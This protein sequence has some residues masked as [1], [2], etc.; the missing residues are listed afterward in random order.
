MKIDNKLMYVLLV[1]VVFLLFIIVFIG[2]DLVGEKNMEKITGAGIITIDEEEIPI[3]EENITEYS[4]L[5]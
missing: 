4:D 3:A 5:G 2:D 1:F